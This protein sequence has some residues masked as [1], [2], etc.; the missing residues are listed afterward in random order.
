MGDFC[1][2]VFV[3]ASSMDHGREDVPMCSRIAF[4]ICFLEV[5]LTKALEIL[6]LRL[7]PP[8]PLNLFVRLRLGSD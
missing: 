1:P 8:D 5:S 7:E 4:E 6:T 2:I 3:L